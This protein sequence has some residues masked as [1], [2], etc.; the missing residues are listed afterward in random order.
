MLGTT[1]P[2]TED[3]VVVDDAFLAPGYGRAGEETL[4]AIKIA[5]HSE[6]LILDPVYTG[7]VM[8]G[9]LASARRDPGRKLMMIHTGGGP[10]IFAYADDLYE[11]LA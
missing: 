11:G 3:D 8:A 7:K 10:A 2:A 1:S 5:A 4:A 6:A 9:T